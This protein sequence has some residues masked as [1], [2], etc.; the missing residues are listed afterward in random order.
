[1]VPLLVAA[2]LPV[3]AR[4]FTPA[5]LE[6]AKGENVAA[7]PL[8]AVEAGGGERRERWRER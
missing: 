5:D 4:H 8:Q 2:E 7:R 1:M 3:L 6:Q